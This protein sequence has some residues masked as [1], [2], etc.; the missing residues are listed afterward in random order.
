MTDPKHKT[1]YPQ[2]GVGY[3][4]LGRVGSRVTVKGSFT[5]LRAYL[6]LSNFGLR[7]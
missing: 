4:P 2:K 1:R 6:G 5:A 3:E 7:A